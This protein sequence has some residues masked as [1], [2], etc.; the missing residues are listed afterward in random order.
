MNEHIIITQLD[1]G[2]LRLTPEDGYTLYNII[3]GRKH[4][5]AEA[6]S[7]SEWRAVLNGI[8]PEP[9]QRTLEDAKK[10]KLAALKAYDSSNAVNSFTLGG[11][12][13][14]VG[15][16][17]RPNLRNTCL[18]YQ[19]KGDEVVSFMGIDIPI[20]TALFVLSK[21]DIYAAECFKQTEAHRAAIN[22]L[23]TIE[24]VDAYDFTVGYPEKLEF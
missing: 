4:S 12:S 16:E 9:H 7:T 8:P 24:A 6:S 23:E 11:I 15:K 5:E 1:S 3:T 13:T 19:E 17:D 10:E 18:A 2:L 14:W 22:A 21:L 20:A